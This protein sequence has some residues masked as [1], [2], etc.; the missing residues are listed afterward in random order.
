MSWWIC[1]ASLG[2][3]PKSLIPQNPEPCPQKTQE[4][5]ICEASLD[6]AAVDDDS[7][8]CIATGCK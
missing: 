8:I 6:V 3:N 1:N 7:M 4:L 5:V 2:P